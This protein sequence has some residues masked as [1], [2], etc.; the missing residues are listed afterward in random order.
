M[1]LL[2]K[3]VGNLLDETA[4]KFSENEALV[5]IPKG[6][7]YSYR[8]FLGAVNRL[9]KG[10]LRLG[11]KKGEH[12]ALWGPNRWEWI[13]TEFAAAKIGVVLISVDRRVEGI[14]IY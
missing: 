14:R 4:L 13:I 8:E 2:K 11:L 6:V 5:D 7:R 10:L 9:S 3:T 12:L 1:G